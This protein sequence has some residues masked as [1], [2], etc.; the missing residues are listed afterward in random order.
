MST[1]TVVNRSVDPTVPTLD[2]KDLR[3]TLATAAGAKR[4]VRDVSFAL[5]PGE[6]VAVVGESGCGKSTLAKAIIGLVDHRSGRVEGSI[7]FHGQELVGARETE[8]RQVRGVGISIVFQ[9][10]T[11]SLDPVF[12]IGYQLIEVL[13]IRKGLSRTEARATAIRLL[14]D[15]DIPN[16]EQRLDDYPH[17][18]SGGLKQRVAIAVAIAT[19]P[20]VLIADEPTTALDVTVQAEVLRVIK[21]LV[22]DLNMSLIFITHDLGVARSIADRILV[23]YAGE[24]VEVGPLLQILEKPGHPY[25]L[26]LKHSEPI[27]LRR[28]E[29]LRPIPGSPPSSFSEIIGCSFA[30]RCPFAQEICRTTAPDLILAAPDQWSR[31]HFAKEVLQSDEQ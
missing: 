11:D 5:K 18:L 30:P 23:M 1:T 24:I 19:G 8:L 2:I 22:A 13:R 15:V 6:T 3:V 21:K 31:C 12:T 27:T 7:R 14:E 20:S 9:D 4:I 25:T 29:R 10:A 26:G 17:Q 28:G 16:A